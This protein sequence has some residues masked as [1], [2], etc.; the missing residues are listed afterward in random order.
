[1]TRNPGDMAGIGRGSGRCGDH[2]PAQFP[3]SPHRNACHSQA[4][5]WETILSLYKHLVFEEAWIVIII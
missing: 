2:F 3:P 1:M 4:L 5:A